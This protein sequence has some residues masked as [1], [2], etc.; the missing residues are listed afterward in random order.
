MGERRCIGE[1]PAVFWFR[2]HSWGVGCRFSR[3]VLPVP[4]MD[5]LEAVYPSRSR[6]V[7]YRCSVYFRCHWGLVWVEGTIICSR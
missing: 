2:G 6:G 4:D 1:H 3:V 5:T 7:S